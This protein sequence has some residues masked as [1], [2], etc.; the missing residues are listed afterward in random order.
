MVQLFTSHMG[1][2][3]ILPAIQQRWMHSTSTSARQIGT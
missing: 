3:S 1:S 2:Q